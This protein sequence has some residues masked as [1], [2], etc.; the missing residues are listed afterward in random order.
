MTARGARDIGTMLAARARYGRRTGRPPPRRQV[1]HISALALLA[2]MLMVAVSC[3]SSGDPT[4]SVPPPASTTPTAQAT[5]PP[6]VA[7]PAVESPNAVA[8]TAPTICGIEVR[9]FRR[10]ERERAAREC[11]LDAHERGE[12][13]QFFFTGVTREGDPFGTVFM[14]TA[15]GID[16]FGISQ[17]RFGMS[18]Q[19]AFECSRVEPTDSDV[20]FSVADC[21]PSAAASSPDPET[22]DPTHPP[23]VCGAEVVLHSSEHINEEARRCFHDAF[24]IEVPARLFSTWFTVEGDPISEVLTV[25]AGDGIAVYRDSR[26]GFGAMGRFTFRCDGLIGTD[27]PRVFELSGCTEPIEVPGSAS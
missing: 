8:M 20:V 6:D 14:A 26:D 11:F 13:A 10:T 25:T 12:E 9:G 1:A 15:G 19:F 5:V 16:A 4:A 17:D 2:A 18:G 7:P 24:Q 27:A 3:T 21:T 23:I 22:A